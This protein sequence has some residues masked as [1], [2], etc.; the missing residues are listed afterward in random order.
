MASGIGTGCSAGGGAVCD[1]TTASGG[2]VKRIT[3]P[4]A[5][6]IVCLPVRLLANHR[7]FPHLGHWVVKTMR[8]SY[9]HTKKEGHGI[10]SS[11]ASMCLVNTPQ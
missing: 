4:H 11:Q 9:A 5:G 8:L 2:G 6:Q 1:G 3:A 7:I 10:V